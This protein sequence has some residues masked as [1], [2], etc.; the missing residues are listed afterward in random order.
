MFRSEF[1]CRGHYVREDLFCTCESEHSL[2]SLQL[3]SCLVLRILKQI[4]VLVVYVLKRSRPYYW[5]FSDLFY[6][7][8][9]I[10]WDALLCLQHLKA[11]DTGKQEGEWANDAVKAPA[12]WIN[13]IYWTKYVGEDQRKYYLRV[14]LRFSYRSWRVRSSE[15]TYHVSL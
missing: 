3:F 14:G 2:E 1:N 15:V 8:S 6:W 4:F 10:C 13:K 9:A 7:T 11:K 5:F 12:V